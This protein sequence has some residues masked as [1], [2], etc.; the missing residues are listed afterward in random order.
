MILV[1]CLSFSSTRAYIYPEVTFKAFCRTLGLFVIIT[2][3][4]CL[5]SMKV[6]E[7][8][9]DK[10][11]A[12]AFYV[13]G[14][15]IVLLLFSTWL[16]RG[17]TWIYVVTLILLAII[18]I[19]TCMRIG[20][21]E[22]ASVLLG[23]WI[24]SAAIIIISAILSNFVFYKNLGYVE[25][26]TMHLKDNNLMDYLKRGALYFGDYELRLVDVPMRFVDTPGSDFSVQV[27]QLTRNGG[28]VA[29]FTL[30]K[31]GYA[32]NVF[33]N[34]GG[35]EPV[36]GNLDIEYERKEKPPQE[37]SQKSD[38][39]VKNSTKSGQN[40]KNSTNSDKTL[41]NSMEFDN[42]PREK[43]ESYADAFFEGVGMGIIQGILFVIIM[44]ILG[45]IGFLMK[46]K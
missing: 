36:S 10:P 28:E 6:F 12:L 19:F 32:R 44:G 24:F 13:V 21:K 23:G 14:M 25:N 22:W 42:Q 9:K 5:I 37:I 26:E 15:M 18:C 4:V 43:E 34:D 20:K 30:N 35:S 33:V 31:D 46:K 1:N 8:E 16:S 38:K 11:G 3:L 39:N 7:K 29:A 17:S 2:S 41:E 45:L 40:V 27:I